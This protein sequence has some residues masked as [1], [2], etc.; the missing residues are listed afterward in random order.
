MQPQTWDSP[1]KHLDDDYNLKYLTSIFE[2]NLLRN[3]EI[4]VM[5]HDVYSHQDDPINLMKIDPSLS[6]WQAKEKEKKP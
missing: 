3:Y 2:K 4:M 6:L 5:Y 1:F